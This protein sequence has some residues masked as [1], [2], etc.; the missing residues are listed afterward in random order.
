[1][2]APELAA[3]VLARSEGNAFLAEELLAAGGTELPET[4]R[5]AMMARIEQLSEGARAALRVAACAGASVSH[6]LLAATVELQELELEDAMREAVTHHVLV[7]SGSDAYAFR[8]ALMREAVYADVLPGARARLHAAI[9]RALTNAPDLASEGATVTAAELAQHWKSAHELDEALAASVDAGRSAARIAAFP[10]AQRHFEYALDVWDR[11]EGAEA[12]AGMDRIDLTRRAADAANLAADRE[13]AIALARDAV[14]QVDVER[15]PVRAGLVQE[16]LG[17]YL[18]LVGRGDEAAAACRAAVATLPADPPS[19]ERARVVAAEGQLLMLRGYVRDSIARCEEALAVAR[20]VGARA[21]EG[22][23]LNTLGACR[24]GLGEHAAAE[25]CLREALAIALELRDFDD[26]GRA[27]VNLGD[28]R[29]PGGPDRRSRAARARRPRGRPFTGARH[30]LPRDAAGRGGAAHVPRRALGPR[31]AA[32]GPGA[33]AARGRAG[34]GESRTRPSLRSRPRAAI[35]APRGTASRVRVR[36]SGPRHQRC[37]TRRSTRRPPSSS[38]QP[39]RAAAARDLV[40]RGLARSEGQEYPF[41]TARLHW[42]GVRVE[43]ELAEGARARFDQPGEREAQSRA[44]DLAERI[45]GQVA[46]TRSGAPAPEVLLYDALCVAEL[47]RAAHA[48]D[49]A[50]WDAPI[51]RADALGIPAAGAYARWRQ[52]EA[53]LV[54]GQRHDAVGPLRVAAATAAELGARPLLDEIRA[55]ARRGRIDLGDAADRAG[56]DDLD[57]TARERDVLRLVAAGRTNREIGAELFISPKT[58]SVHVS[59]ILRKLNVRGRVEA[60]AVAHRRGL[61][62]EPQSS[63][64]S[65]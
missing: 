23:A 15:D 26:I 19:A 34:R 46:E 17:R 45:A 51:A 31:R 58:A 36:G 32:G 62:S 47:T 59:R 35:P 63:R 8:H 1:M 61:E 65:T 5:E 53:A 60:A 48:P 4:V 25:A 20:A 43:A 6:R 30:R 10:E 33:R 42:V 14:A 40:M 41:Y 44:A 50:A 27:Y 57:L 11:V 38:C 13:R 21:Q 22:H 56:G 52:A 2:P 64:R 29:R 37:G 54:L 16:R 55:L 7:R 39:G 28:V 18:W 12:R 49:P 3:Q 24:S 9:A